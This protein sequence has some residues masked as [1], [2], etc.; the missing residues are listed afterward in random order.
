MHVTH[1]CTAAP[2]K[3]AGLGGMRASNFFLVDRVCSTTIISVA[4]R[5]LLPA[6]G[7]PTQGT[8]PALLRQPSV[9]TTPSKSSCERL[10]YYKTNPNLHTDFPTTYQINPHN[11]SED[12]NGSAAWPV[13]DAALSEC[14][15]TLST[16]LN[17][18]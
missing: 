2:D 18:C 12:A 10:R 6:Q 9:S 16:A 4:I 3:F 15:E 13:A 11:M 7:E 1:H 17:V 14:C 5:I 8:L